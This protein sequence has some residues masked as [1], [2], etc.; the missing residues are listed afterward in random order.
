MTMNGGRYFLLDF[1]RLLLFLGGLWMVAW[2]VA[3]I[4]WRLLGTMEMCMP[5]ALKATP[6]KMALEP[7]KCRGTIWHTFVVPNFAISN[8]TCS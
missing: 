5:R 4:S 6:K 8:F 2:M 1:G 3:L 7:S